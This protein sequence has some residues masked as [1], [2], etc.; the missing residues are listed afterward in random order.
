MLGLSS[1]FLFNN[2]GFP[3]TFGSAAYQQAPTD[4]CLHLKDAS[5]PR[6]PQQ[7]R[8]G[9]AL[10]YLAVSVSPLVMAVNP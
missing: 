6:I 3:W 5:R 1:S 2:G 9:K 7:H 4:Y 10:A 8:D